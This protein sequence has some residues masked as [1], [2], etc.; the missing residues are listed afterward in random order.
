[1]GEEIKASEWYA[2]YA[3]FVVLHEFSE[4]V[5]E[6]KVWEAVEEWHRQFSHSRSR[7]EQVVIRLVPKLPRLFTFR[8]AMVEIDQRG[9][10]IGEVNGSGANYVDLPI[11]TTSVDLLQQVMF[12]LEEPARLAMENLPPETL[13]RLSEETFSWPQ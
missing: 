6:D 10:T 11:A 4:P 7:S 8:I 13:A 3:S 12:G 9:D 1:M 5:G 2:E